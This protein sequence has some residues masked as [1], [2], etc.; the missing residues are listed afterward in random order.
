MPAEY[1]CP[2]HRE[3]LRRH[4]LGSLVGAGHGIMYPVLDGIPVLLP[5]EAERRRV[6][7]TDWSANGAGTT[8]ALAFYNRAQG[9]DDYYQRS[10]L[11]EIGPDTGRWLRE[12]RVEG[13]VLEIGCGRGVLQGLAVDYVALDYSLTA[14]RR[15][16]EPCHQRVCATAESLPF[17]DNTFRFVFTLCVLEHVPHPDRA[18]DEIDR[19]LKPGGIAYL[20]PAWHC[21]QYNC[22]GIPVRPYREL[23]LRQKLVKLSLVVRRRSL[24]KAAA[25]LPGR[26]LRRLLWSLNRRPTRLRY[27]RL[28][29][30]Y[31]RYWMADSDAVSRLDAHEGCLYFHSRGYEILR[32]G[33]GMMSQLLARHEPLIVR[34]PSASPA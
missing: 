33:R 23:S 17:F 7:Q 21:V 10:D 20:L 19:V 1:C 16:I 9:Q 27:Q 25:A 24:A 30:D 15:Y 5:D 14:L 4:G 28:R 18:F 32:P 8:S 2:V 29:P 31:R 13:P 3:P 6:S 34:K 22:E 26:A 12:A 11:G